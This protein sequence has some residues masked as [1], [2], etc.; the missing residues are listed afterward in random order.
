MD[1]ISNKILIQDNICKLFYEILMG[2][3]FMH[4]AGVIQ[5][6]LDPDNSIFVDENFNIKFTQFNNCFLLNTNP[7]ILFNKEYITNSYSYRAPETIWGRRLFRSFNGRE[8]LKSICKLIGEPNVYER[9]YV[10]KGELLNF[11]LEYYRK[12]NFQPTF[13]KI[14]TG[15]TQ[16]QIELLNSMLCWDPRDRF[17]I[18]EIL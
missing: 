16:I 12:F 18:N 7:T 9:G 4:S 10:Q 6:D 11:L 14:F 2:L 17:S 15:C 5:R 1:L 8:H 13:K 3:K